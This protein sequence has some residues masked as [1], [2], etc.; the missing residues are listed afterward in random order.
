MLEDIMTAEELGALTAFVA[1]SARCVLVCHT[2]P[3][4]DA[5]GSCLAMASYVRYKTSCLDDREKREVGEREVSVVVPDMFPDYLRW[6]PGADAIVRYDKHP[7]VARALISSADL[8]FCLDFSDLSRTDAMAEPLRA[9]TARK[10][11]IDHHPNPNVECALAV[12][13]SMLSSTC[14]IVFRIVWQAGD[15]AAMTERFAVPVYCGM[16]TDTGAFTYSSSRPDIF[17]IVS[18]LLTKGIDRDKIYRN[19]YNN[20]SE[21]RLRF[22]G[23]VLYHKLV[24]DPKSHAAFFTITRQ[25]Q[26]RFH[27]IKGDAEGLVNMPL[28]IKG[29]LLSISLR[30]DTERPGLVLV[31]LRSVGQHPCNTIAERFFNGGGHPNASGGRLYCGMTDAVEVACKAI[32]AFADTLK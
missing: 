11:H 29:M 32:A 3:D 12:S 31:S 26:H 17:Y 23:Y 27:F 6:M 10:V 15:F 18:Q 19:V 22:I 16:M 7:D 25:E 28:Q 2:N 1:Q 8:I 9:A 4:G 14:E 24:T 5:I 21:S 13:R 20:Y 30:E